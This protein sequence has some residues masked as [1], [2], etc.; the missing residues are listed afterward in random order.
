MPASCP[1][2]PAADLETVERALSNVSL[3]E[4]LRA[5]ELARVAR[6]F[7]LA[8]LEAGES[9]EFAASPDGL[10]L[11]ILV[12]GEAELEASAAGRTLRSALDPGD[13]F[14]D[15]ALVSGQGRPFRLLARRR[16]CL[17]IID[18]S[19]FSRL[20][21]EFP[22]VALPLA[23]ELST[24]LHGRNDAVRQLLELH[25]EQFP[26]D[27][28]SNALEE[29]RRV[30]TRGRARVARLSPASL[31]R[32]LVVERGEE[33]PFWILL[34]FVVS[35]GLSRLVVFLILRYHLERQLFALIQGVDPNPMHVH[36]F[37][38]GLILLGS[39]GLAALFPFGR[40]ALRLLAFAFGAGSG[41]VFDEF[42][43]IWNL[44][45][46]YSRP[47]SLI[48]SALAAG[49]L[50]QLAYFRRFWSA[51]LRRALAGLRG[52]R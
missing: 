49:V 42:A 40:R 23:A 2:D 20:L 43:L 41:L 12:S 47:S 30:F 35:L 31:F 7:E 52:W 16:S 37:N 48:A 15:T 6:H 8:A 9:R 22:A 45:P 18:R 38:Y 29:R 4:H 11:V 27:E 25:A 1:P 39:A 51:L 24:E 44:N 21:D 33:P 14:G 50:L 28:L 17:A 10:R 3:F 13:R 5:D 32:R 34:G 26:P 19:G 36:H 46:E